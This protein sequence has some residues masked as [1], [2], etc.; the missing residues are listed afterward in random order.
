MLAPG[1]RVA[2]ALSGGPDSVALL[3]LLRELAAAGHLVVAGVAHFNHQLRGAAADADEQFC[4]ELAATLRLPIEVGRADV[5]AA[6]RLEKRSIEDAARR[7]RYAFLR[8]AAER[9][10]AD[11]VAVGHTLDDQAETF[12]LRLIRGAGTRGLGAIRPKAGPIIRP[13]IE[14][15]RAELRQFAADRRLTFQ[16]DAT[17]ADLGIPRNR[18]RHELLPYLQ[19]EFSP[20]IVEVLAREAAIARED[21]DR[22]EREAIE[23]AAS[24]VL[25]DTTIQEAGPTGDRVVID[26]ARLA[27]LHP[28]LG[29]RVARLALERLADGR[30]VDFGAIHG[31]LELARQARPGSSV[32]LPACQARMVQ[33]DR[34]V[35]V[36]GPE[37]ARG[38]RPA[39]EDGPESR[40]SLSIP[41]EVL[42]P[43][44][45]LVISAE[46]ADTGVLPDGVGGAMALV[47]GVQGPLTVR[48]RR[49]G[50]R[51][52][53]PGMGGR[54]KKLQDYLVDRK[55][56]RGERDHLP[57][58]ADG[59]D[60]I[61]WIVGHAVAEG[62]QAS[63]P[64]TGVILLIARHLGG[65]V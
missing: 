55:V 50:D 33:R 53:P 11:A 56:P 28:A 9:L 62:H 54:T 36:L 34:L 63:G 25:T 32:S 59:A 24:I 46:P 30:F 51:F 58:V 38:Q 64:S 48:F 39:G 3:Y 42:L 12:L 13:A 17:N 52:Q 44:S 31:V 6:A 2:V 29:A 47:R 20:S 15:S 8:S 41:G 10:D 35:I 60:R 65:E 40:F 26:A 43:G 49:P 16:D 19:R 57:L 61:V 5:R 18:V 21:D 7:L 4:R 1:G 37:P 45:G 23:S 14:L 27:S 22:L